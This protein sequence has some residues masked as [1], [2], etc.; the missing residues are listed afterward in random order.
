MQARIEQHLLLQQTEH[1][2]RVETR[3]EEEVIDGGDKG[4]QAE[5]GRSSSPLPGI[6]TK[7]ETVGGVERED[8]SCASAPM[9]R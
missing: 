8:T 6:P 1:S 7:T 3:V 9:S 4:G 5:A 2:T